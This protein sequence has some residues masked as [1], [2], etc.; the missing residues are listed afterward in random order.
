MDVSGRTVLITGATGGLGQAI[1]RTFAARGA[2]LIVTGRRSEVLEPLA[3][4]LS[5]RVIAVDLSDAADVERLIAETG[6]TDVL[7]ANAA[8]PASGSLDDF[9]VEEIDR[10]LTVNLRAPIILSREL[11]LR[12]VERGAGHIVLMSSL[13]G[14]AATPGS[15]LY[16]A[17]K[18]GLRGFGLGLRQDW[19]QKGVGVSIVFPGFIRDAGMFHESG[20]KLPPG[21]GTRRP[22]DV[23]EGTLK[24]VQRNLAEVEVAPV[25]L[26]AGTLFS[27]IAPELA[28]K[29][30]RRMGAGSIAKDMASGQRG[31]R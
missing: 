22:E 13:S 2:S 26:R 1:A 31:K 18:F 24:A 21:V 17:T 15:A 19:E 8:L 16:S 3:T 25:A 23:A 7:I 5:A 6:D 9:S 29:V 28:A 4:E 14:K 20:T 30:S 11:G 10:A 12:M 27:Q